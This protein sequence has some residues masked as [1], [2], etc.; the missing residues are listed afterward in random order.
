MVTGRPKISQKSPT[1]D[2]DIDIKKQQYR[3]A[4]L[5]DDLPQHVSDN[6][7]DMN[8]GRIQEGNPS[9]GYIS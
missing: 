4:F 6:P 1:N 7:F 5:Y 8:S 9:L 2:L 3:P